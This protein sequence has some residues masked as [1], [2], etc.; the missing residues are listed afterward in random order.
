MSRR[1]AFDAEHRVRHAA[2]SGGAWASAS[3]RRRRPS[4][5]RSF[6]DDE[7]LAWV[8]LLMRGRLF[9]R[10]GIELDVA[11]AR[12]GS[13]IPARRQKQPTASRTT[14]TPLP[15]PLGH[16]CRSA[17]DSRAGDI[18]RDGCCR[19]PRV[20][21]AAPPRRDSRGED[22]DLVA[23]CRELRP[24]RQVSR[25]APHRGIGRDAHA[26]AGPLEQGE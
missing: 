18:A 25:K 11:P 13:E 23:R 2:S 21:P 17:A 20:W 24:A 15:R 16:R 14:R 12:S 7:Q 6:R 22:L 10:M 1:L 4:R 8:R 9:Q 5:T 19:A 26:D 3:G